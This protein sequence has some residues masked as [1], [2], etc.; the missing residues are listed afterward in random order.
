MTQPPQYPSY[1]GDE[2]QS[3]G[4]GQPAGGQYP[5]PPPGAPGQPPVWGAY[6]PPPAW[7]AGPPVPPASYASWGSRLGA[8]V[9]DSLLGFAV[10]LVPLA[11]GAAVAFAD[12]DIDPVTDDI[13]G[14]EALGF[15]IMGIGFVL[16][17]A[18]DVWNR[19]LRTGRTGQS[20]G[21]KALGIRVVGK[22]TQQVIGR[23]AGFGRWA[24]TFAFGVV[25]YLGACIQLLDG[26]WPLWD[27]DNQALHDKVVTTVVVRT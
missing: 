1:P 9:L 14:V 25:P 12:A 11:V 4:W 24:I 10:A 21:K 6:G 7:T 13:S 15:V 27:E 17:L 18:F 3:S 16:A 5:P 22:N 2:P 23:A 19:G 26:L 8:L 20:L